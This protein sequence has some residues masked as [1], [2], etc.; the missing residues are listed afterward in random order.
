MNRLLRFVVG[1]YLVM[2][3][4]VACDYAF[5]FRE[6]DQHGSLVPPASLTTRAFLCVALGMGWPLSFSYLLELRAEENNRG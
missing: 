4:Y 3:T 2:A 6:M 5:L 1:L